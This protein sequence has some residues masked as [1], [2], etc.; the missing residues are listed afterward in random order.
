MKLAIAMIVVGVLGVIAG[1][2]TMGSAA[3]ELEQAKTADGYA[4]AMSG[5]QFNGQGAIDAAQGMSNMGLGLLVAFGLV[6]VLGVTV[7]AIRSRS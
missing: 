1:G 3:G 2:I 5:G 4:V 7:V 6:A